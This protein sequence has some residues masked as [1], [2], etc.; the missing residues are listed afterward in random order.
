MH[1]Y[2]KINPLKRY[3]AEI[4]LIVKQIKDSRLTFPNSSPTS[5]RIIREIY[6]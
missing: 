2:F 1:I 3:N 5:K 4:M 6:E